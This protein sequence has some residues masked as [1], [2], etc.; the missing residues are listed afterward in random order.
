VCVWPCMCVCVWEAVGL[1]NWRGPRFKLFIH[2][3]PTQKRRSHQ[4]PWS[5]R[6]QSGATA[7]ASVRYAGAIRL[8]ASGAPRAA[9][10]YQPAHPLSPLARPNASPCSRRGARGCVK[11][12]APQPQSRS[13]THR[14]LAF[15]HHTLLRS[16]E[17][18]GCVHTG[19]AIFDTMRHIRPVRPP[20]LRCC[21]SNDPSPTHVSF[22]APVPAK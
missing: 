17:R 11:S 18:L 3:A 20:S 21:D 5:V 16:C 12:D 4:A 15:D 8:A 19:M 7:T 10:Q 9:T 13:H 6:S 22:D 1:C 14:A 2:T